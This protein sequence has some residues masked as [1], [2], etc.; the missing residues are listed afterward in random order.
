MPFEKDPNEIGTLWLKSGRKGEY[1]TGE[2]AGQRVVLFPINSKNPKAP[3]WRV[4]KSTG[5][6]TDG[7]DQRRDNSTP[8]DDF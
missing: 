1:M 7:H 5:K 4:L 2:I 8:L 3:N 6:D